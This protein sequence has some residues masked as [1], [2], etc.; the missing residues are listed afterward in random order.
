MNLSPVLI[1]DLVR[2]AL[3]EDF[4]H[5]H[6]STTQAL[7]PADR[8]GRLVMVAREDGVLA[9]SDIA[10]A[11]FHVMDATLDVTEHISDGNILKKGD[12]I[13]SVEG[14]AQSILSAERVALNFMSHLSG[15]A[16]ATALYVAAVQG[17][18][19]SIACTR[20]TLPGL[21]AVQKYAVR[22]GGGRNHRFGLDDGILIKDNHIAIAGSIADAIA[23]ARSHSGHMVKI[24]IEVDTLDQL[25][26]AL[27]H[28]I[29]AVLLDNMP[30]EILKKAVAMIDGRALA[31][32]SGG[33]TLDTVPAI[34][35]AGVDLIS[36]G[37][38]THSVTALDIGLDIHI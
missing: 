36:V 32:A 2:R 18:K 5:G 27:A 19:T 12:Q 26:D 9:G 11:A 15:I 6:D 20:K 16:S 4:G 21:R 34:A 14:A 8:Q 10:Q 1:D 3:R 33:I 24:E 37:A 23:Q 35:A 29:D 13:I 7:I 38:L 25:K 28:R 30:P 22:M 31:E 17:T